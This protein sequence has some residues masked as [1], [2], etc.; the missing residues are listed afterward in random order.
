[1]VESV[2]LAGIGGVAGLGLAVWTGRLVMGMLPPDAVEVLTANLDAR[3]LL[4]NL[5]IAVLTGLLFGLAPA[6]QA[7]RPELAGTLKDQAGSVAGGGG[8]ARK[9]LVAAQVALS[10]ML[11]FGA[12]LFVR[13]LRNLKSL[14]PG[15][16]KDNLVTFSVDP[17]LSGYRA[18]RAFAFYRQLLE[19]LES[20]PGVRSAALAQVPILSNSSWSSSITVEGYESKPGE[21]MS[22]LFN[23]VSPGYFSTLGIPL[24]LGR[25]F[26]LRDDRAAPKVCIVNETFVQYF[27]GGRDPLGRRIRMQGDREIIGVVRDV[28]YRNVKEEVPRQVFLPYLQATEVFGMAAWVR[29]ASS[30][31]AVM[32]ASRRAVAEL[33][34]KLPVY[35]VQTME[36]QIDNVLVA[37]RVVATL[38]ASF[39]VLATVLAVVGLYGVMAHSVARRTREIG[40]RIALGAERRNLVWTVMRE[41]LLL[42]GVGMAVGLPSAWGLARLAQSLLFD[43]QPADPLTL[44]AV[45]AGM[46][47]VACL[48]GYGP[49]ARAAK[50]DP[51]VALRYE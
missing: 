16:R 31:Q 6:L 22:P 35:R 44:A 21:N 7:T 24:L 33:D 42:A 30:P 18:E 14:D 25:D 45:A 43:V 39:G 12:G 15:F 17:A 13:S 3:A 48:A 32:A 28:K 50:V 49:A 19:K 9:A 29:A 51:V 23:Q 26:T 2:L 11:L 41:V 34:A 5:A 46:T 4:F 10:V 36:A 47:L 8:G 37:E 20:A 1:L 40:I 27:Y 38:A